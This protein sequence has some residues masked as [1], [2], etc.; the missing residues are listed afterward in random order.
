MTERYSY[1]LLL[2]SKGKNIFVHFHFL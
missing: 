2:G 1:L